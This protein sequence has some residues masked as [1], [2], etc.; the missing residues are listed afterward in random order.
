MVTSIHSAKTVVQVLKINSS[1]G[2]CPHCGD[3]KLIQS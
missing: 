1:K 2:S 3:G